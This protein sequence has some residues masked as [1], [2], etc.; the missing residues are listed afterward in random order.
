MQAAVQA[1]GRNFEHAIESANAWYRKRG[2]A[3]IAKVPVLT[4]VTG[5]GIARVIG[6]GPVDWVGRWGST[7][8]AF[9]TKSTI[10]EK[11]HLELPKMKATKKGWRQHGG[12]IHQAEF[13]LDWLLSETR[14][15]PVPGVGD[16]V[17]V[18]ELAV[19]FL[20][21]EQRDQQRAYIVH[22]RPVLEAL[23]EGKH[24][25][26]CKGTTALWPFVAA[27]STLD[28][29]RGTKP[30]YDYLEVLRR[31]FPRE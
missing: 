6:K 31:V 25:R 10:T 14:P 18:K 1:T 3:V 8:I 4:Q 29:A 17:G 15:E 9:D 24:I 16:R 20:L 11:F 5:R 7:P 22:G 21:V 23:R 28:I 27:S 13:L 30:H 12:Q 2:V 26:V 19:G